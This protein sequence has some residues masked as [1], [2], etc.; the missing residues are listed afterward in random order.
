MVAAPNASGVKRGS[1]SA[2]SEFWA[3]YVRKLFYGARLLR[4]SGMLVLRIVS[5][6]TPTPRHGFAAYKACSGLDR[7]GD[8]QRKLRLHC[9]S[10]ICAVRF[11]VPHVFFS[12]G[13]LSFWQA[14][15][16]STTERIVRKGRADNAKSQ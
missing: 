4:E 6:S 10:V 14:F 16:S 9:T 15:C 12:L 2:W 1:F 8:Q 3:R 5:S 13:S 11:V 7:A